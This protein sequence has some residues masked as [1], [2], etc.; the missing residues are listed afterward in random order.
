MALQSGPLLFSNTMGENKFILDSKALKE[1][2]LRAHDSGTFQIPTSKVKYRKMVIDLETEKAASI[3]TLDMLWSPVETVIGSEKLVGVKKLFSDNCEL[4]FIPR[5]IADIKNVIVIHLYQNDI[6]EV[7]LWISDLQQLNVLD[8]SLNKNLHSLP[9]LKNLKLLNIIH[10]DLKFLPE[11]FFQHR[12]ES[13]Y[14]QGNKNLKSVPSIN[15]G[16]NVSRSRSAGND[17]SNI[18]ENY[19]M[20]AKTVL[21]TREVVFF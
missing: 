8:L 21:V 11:D 19:R 1:N 9:T 14:M 15:E 18:L 20:A 10:C 3:E 13:V 6:Q 17:V 12:L 2:N 5:W 7:P 16:S 4:S